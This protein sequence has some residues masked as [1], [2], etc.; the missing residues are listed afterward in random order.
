MSK[1]TRGLIIREPW[2]GMIVDG[3]KTWEIRSR[4]TDI[5]GRIGLIRGGSGLIVGSA[6]LYGTFPVTKGELLESMDQHGMS[7]AEVLALFKPGSNYHKPWVWMMRDSKPFT[8]PRPY[9]HPNGAVIWVL[10]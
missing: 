10:L 7:R 3:R 4:D 1:L 8:P 6:E 5:R 2:V 9:T